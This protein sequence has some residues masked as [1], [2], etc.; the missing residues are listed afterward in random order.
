MAIDTDAKRRTALVMAGRIVRLP[1]PTDG[2]MD[3]SAERFTVLGLYVGFAT[4]EATIGASAGDRQ[5]M[6]SAGL[7]GR[8]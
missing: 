4:A 6:R 8:V 7:I 5:R 1:T 3:V 2:N